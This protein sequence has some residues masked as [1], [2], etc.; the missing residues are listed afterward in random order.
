MV[1][2][3][4]MLERDWTRWKNEAGAYDAM[5]GRRMRRE[6]VIE[7]AKN[8]EMET[9]PWTPMEVY[10]IFEKEALALIGDLHR[11]R[12]MMRRIRER[13]PEDG[14]IRQLTEYH[15]RVIDAEIERL[16][17]EVRYDR[18]TMRELAEL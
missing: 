1:T 17:E 9:P 7:S 11:D 12:G 8:K 13:F 14:K 15:L 16:V 3:A 2:G 18:E 10:R 5:V 4:E 6:A